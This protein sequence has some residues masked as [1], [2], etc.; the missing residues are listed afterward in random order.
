MYSGL[1][2]F[3]RCMCCKYSSGFS[4]HFVKIFPGKKISIFSKNLICH[5]LML[6][7]SKTSLKIIVFSNITEIF[8]L[9]FSSRKFSFSFYVW[10]YK[11]FQFNLSYAIKILKFIFAIYWKVFFLP[12]NC[13]GLIRQVWIYFWTFF[14]FHWCLC[15]SF[16]Q[17]LTLSCLL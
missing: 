5:F 7:C 4:I 9:M 1:E 15:L 16:Q 17:Y 10:I 11:P 8:Y 12:L 6:T 14:Q 3:F 2:Y 13:F